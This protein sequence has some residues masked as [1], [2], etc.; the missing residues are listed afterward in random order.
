MMVNQALKMFEEKLKGFVSGEW[1]KEPEKLSI[2]D[3][4]NKEDE[5]QVLWMAARDA[6]AGMKKEI[7]ARE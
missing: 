1:V 3:Q 2:S 4:E 7:E 6:C 5:L